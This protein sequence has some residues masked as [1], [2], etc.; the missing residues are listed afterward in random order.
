MQRGIEGSKHGLIISLLSDHALHFH[1]DQIAL[2]ENREP[3]ATVCSLRDKVIM[4]SLS[5]FIENIINSENPK[6]MFD[7]CTDQISKVFQLKSS[8]K[9]MRGI[10]IEGMQPMA[11][12]T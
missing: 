2:Y 8:I 7:L 5:A 9:H 12:K 4:E 6:Q 3:S 10:D 11:E 1:Q